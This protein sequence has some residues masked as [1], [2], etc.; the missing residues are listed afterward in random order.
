V[1]WLPTLSFELSLVVPNHETFEKSAK[2]LHSAY[3]QMQM[4]KQQFGCYAKVPLV[5]V[6]K[7]VAV[8]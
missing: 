3:D 2:A 1:S 7:F 8:A 6:A 4:P 5:A